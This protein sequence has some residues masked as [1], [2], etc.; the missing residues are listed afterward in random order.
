MNEVSH[1]EQRTDF[2]LCMLHD[3]DCETQSKTD[4]NKLGKIKASFLGC[5]VCLTAEIC[6]E[7]H[8]YFCSQVKH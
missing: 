5:S 1:N 3:G 6:D 7:H 2:S 4:M 8:H